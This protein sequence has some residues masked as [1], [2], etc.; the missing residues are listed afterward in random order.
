MSEITVQF[1]SQ[2][3]YTQSHPA[4]L[5]LP[6]TGEARVALAAVVLHQVHAGA[7]VPTW[8]GLAV[9]DVQLTRLAA[10]PRVGAVAAELVDAV[11][12]GAV[13]EART[14]LGDHRSGRG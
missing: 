8:L 3:T 10:E 14:R 12:A 6:L 5:P 1:D 4:L 11:D 9:V 7:A 2:L 13:V